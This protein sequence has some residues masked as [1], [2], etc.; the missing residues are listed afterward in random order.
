MN[1]F[2]ICI[3]LSL[4]TGCGEPDVWNGW[5]YPDG[6]NLLIDIPIGEF[7]S[8]ALCRD[9]AVSRLKIER[10]YRN[11]RPIKGDYECGLNCKPSSHG[12]NIC[13]ETKR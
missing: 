5:V 12:T 10:V 3:S 8:L 7:E 4:L 11:G 6:A 9:A 1:K 2:A 13:E